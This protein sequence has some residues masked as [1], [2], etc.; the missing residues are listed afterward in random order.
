MSK[1]WVSSTLAAGKDAYGDW[2]FGDGKQFYPVPGAPLV[3]PWFH[4]ILTIADDK[5]L[6]DLFNLPVPPKDA[7]QDQGEFR[8]QPFWRFGDSTWRT[9]V[10]DIP[11]LVTQKFLSV[12]G[13]NA[14]WR[15]VIPSVQLGVPLD[16]FPEGTKQPCVSSPDHVSE[17]LEPRECPEGSKVVVMGVIDDGIAFG[18]ERFQIPGKNGAAAQTRVEYA[19]VQDGICCDQDGACASGKSP[20]TYGRE[21]TKK[22]IDDLL[23]RSPTDE[24]WFY[25]EVGLGDFSR[26]GLKSAMFRQ[27]HGTHVM[28]LFA[29]AP[30]EDGVCNRPIVCVQ[31]PTST[32]ADTSGVSFNPNVLDAVAYI[33]DR[34][35]LIAEAYE[36]KA[37]PV[38]INFS[39]GIFAGP[40]DGASALEREFDRL[41][42]E[43]TRDTGQPTDIVIPAGN[44]HQARDHARIRF[45]GKKLNPQTL[46]WRVLPNDRTSSFIE[47]WL[48]KRDVKAGKKARVKLAVVPPFGASSPNL[49]DKK[50]RKSMRWTPTGKAAQ[51]ALC[52]VSY[53][54][55]PMLDGRGR[56]VVAI[57]PTGFEHASQMLSPAGEWQLQLTNLNL[58]EDEIIEAWIQRDDAPRGFWQRGRQSYFADCFYERFDPVSGRI[59]ENDT[60]ESLVKRAGMLNAIATGSETVVIGGFLEKELV[61]TEYT[62]SGPVPADNAGWPRK[63]PDALAV[64]D[65]SRV[66]RGVMAA[67]TRSGS[68]VLIN[69]TSVA[70]PQIAKLLADARANRDIRPGRVIVS[71]IA[72][73]EELRLPVED[74][75]TSPGRYGHGRIRSLSR[76][77]MNRI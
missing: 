73:K 23:V 36:L 4:A 68:R 32:T 58:D 19:W 14:D 31:L 20:V 48:P 44:G 64:A 50:P 71:E 54:E 41:I 76:D 8:I 35:E 51:P 28:D 45:S 33:L 42:R 26:R 17:P 37:V 22:M 7:D 77:G 53:D 25:K 66:H 52:K 12:L 9:G 29:G 57:T 55:P 27:A 3:D 10:K 21:F 2:N 5:N 49:K 69:G 60:I 65:E 40:H 34:A 16:A 75:R 61:A 15:A 56:F 6:S 72:E 30:S 46:R 13:E 63:G 74:R 47:I 67:G 38:V 59:K 70:V 11:A 1:Q 62:A 18:H 43:R 24:D 39:Y